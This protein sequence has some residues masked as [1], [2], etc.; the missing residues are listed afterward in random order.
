M[1]ILQTICGARR[2]EVVLFS[3]LHT[4]KSLESLGLGMRLA[5]RGDKSCYF[6]LPS[7]AHQRLQSKESLECLSVRGREG[8]DVTSWALNGM[9]VYQ[10]PFNEQQVYMYR[11]DDMSCLVCLYFALNQLGF[12][13]P[14]PP[15]SQ[16]SDLH[17]F[18]SFNQTATIA[19]LQLHSTLKV[20]YT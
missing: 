7:G 20:A 13:P 16:H 11:K 4:R 5:L 2:R 10:Q 9:C 1:K 6:Y 8:E 19:L 12:V 14:P 17:T 3:A 18:P 15:Q